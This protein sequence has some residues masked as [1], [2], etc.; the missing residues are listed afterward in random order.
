MLIY[1]VSLWPLISRRRIWNTCHTAIH[2]GSSRSQHTHF[3]ATWRR[4]SILHGPFP[5]LLEKFLTKSKGKHGLE[6][7]NGLSTKNRSSSRSFNA[8][9]SWQQRRTRP[10][11]STHVPAELEAEE[12]VQKYPA[13]HLERKKS[14]D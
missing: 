1:F 2:F 3:M 6:E 9:S 7:V 12:H 5:F 8:S 4:S 14:T 10:A 13:S 11:G